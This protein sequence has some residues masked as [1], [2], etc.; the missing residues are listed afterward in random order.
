MPPGQAVPACVT[1]G[2]LMRH[3]LERTPDLNPAF[4]D[5]ARYYKQHGEALRV[6]WDYAFYQMLLE[7]NY[8]SYKTRQRPLG[9]RRSQ[10][11]QLRRHR[12]NGRRRAGRQLPGRVERR[13]GADAA[14]HRLFRRAGGEARWR[15]ARARSRTTSSSSRGRS[16]R[17]VRFSDLTNRWAADRNY[18]TSIEFVAERYRQANCTATGEP[19][20][21]SDEDLD[22][23]R[24]RRGRA[25]QRL[26]VLR[27][28]E[29][30]RIARAGGA[31]P[32]PLRRL[33]RQLR[34]PVALLIRSVSAPRPTTPCCRWM[35]SSSSRRPTPSS[36]S[37]APN[38]KTIARFPS[39]EPAFVRAFELCPG[40]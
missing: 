30:P 25:W 4:R 10:A 19:L 38:G 2:R 5:I 23:Q 33:H 21:P 22:E 15:R 37:H 28:A 32:A 39:P 17:P 16:R 27:R 29:E 34:R 31:A 26:P 35:R 9:R 1:P 7:T 8:L 6:R 36:R 14:S 3:V 13:A 40:P 11:E 20:H 24:S 18:A 12:H